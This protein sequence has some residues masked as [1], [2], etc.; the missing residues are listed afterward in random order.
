MLNSILNQDLISAYTLANQGNQAFQR[1]TSRINEVRALQLGSC[2]AVGYIANQP[3]RL[4]GSALSCAEE[5]PKEIMDK[6]I[7]LMM[8]LM[9]VIIAPITEELAFRQY[10]PETIIPQ[11]HQLSSSQVMAKTSIAFGVVH[12]SN[13]FMN[14]SSEGMRRTAYQVLFCAVVLGP[15]CHLAKEKVGISGS[16]LLHMG[17]NYSAFSSRFSPKDVKRA[18]KEV[19]GEEVA[20]LVVQGALMLGMNYFLMR[21][22][23]RMEYYLMDQ[24][25]KPV[26]L[27]QARNIEV[28]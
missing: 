7:V 15:L 26:A 22:L 28:I 27:S 2:V 11:Y 16:I 25:D 5:D 4:V 13:I 14:P 18:L 20:S 9:A 21:F 6:E 17:F 24:L 23:A 3:V 12:L 8:L 1:L 10:L 19:S